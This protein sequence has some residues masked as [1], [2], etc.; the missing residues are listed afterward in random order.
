[1][2]QCPSC[3]VS[4]L[5]SPQFL[6]LMRP[7]SYFSI[8]Y[9]VVQSKMA[10]GDGLVAGRKSMG[11]IAANSPR[12]KRTVLSWH[13]AFITL[14]D[15]THDTGRHLAAALIEIYLDGDAVLDGT[16]LNL[17]QIAPRLLYCFLLI[18]IP[19]AG[20][21]GVHGACFVV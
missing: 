4:R 14:F 3:L 12:A 2:S 20:E 15:K 9:R 6:A 16:A 19:V 21:G 11:V 17:S 13:G 8:F 1:M 18:L 5:A 7:G 10:A